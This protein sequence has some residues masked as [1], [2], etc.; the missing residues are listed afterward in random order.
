MELEIVVYAIHF[1]I[2]VMRLNLAIPRLSQS[3]LVRVPFHTDD[4][5]GACTWSKLN[6]E[7]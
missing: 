6:L 7:G 4:Y 1:R 3:G 5:A 2:L